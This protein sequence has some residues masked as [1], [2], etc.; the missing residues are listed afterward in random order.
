VSE[1]ELYGVYILINMCIAERKV[2]GNK[3]PNDHH[4]FI[5]S[6]MNEKIAS[7]FW[8]FDGIA[9]IQIKMSITQQI[10]NILRPNMAEGCLGIEKIHFIEVRG[11]IMIYSIQW[12]HIYIHFATIC[13]RL[14]VEKLMW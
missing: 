14:P 8:K 11:Q 2:Q 10:Q 5:F 6:K 7:S 9:S 12:A 1:L 3:D 4:S 13:I